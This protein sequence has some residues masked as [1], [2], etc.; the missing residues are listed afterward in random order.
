MQGRTSAEAV[1]NYVDEANRLVSCLTDSIVSVGGGYHPAASPLILALNNGI[2]VGL[3]GASRFGLQLQQTYRIV[4]PATRGDL[5]TVRVTGYAYAV[6]DANQREVLTYHWHPRSNSPVAMPH[7]HLEQGALVGRSEVRD[8]HLPTG[9]I[10][11]GSFLRFL[12]I[13]LSVEPDRTDWES[14]LPED[15]DHD[16]SR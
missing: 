11:I 10:S 16:P 13:D 7:L 6:L 15:W 2:I 4:E 14:I 1:N 3:R 8:A 9:V 12:I 5:W